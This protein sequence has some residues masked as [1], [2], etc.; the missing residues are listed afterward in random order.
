[1]SSRTTSLNNNGQN[2]RTTSANTN[3][4]RTSSQP[5]LDKDLET[6]QR[7]ISGGKPIASGN[8]F[9]PLFTSRATTT[10]INGIRSLVDGLFDQ[11]ADR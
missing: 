1:M 6:G 3:G 7:T 10:N 4:H 9:I 5:L 8:L 11:T 2:S